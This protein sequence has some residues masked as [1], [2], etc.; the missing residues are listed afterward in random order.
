MKLTDPWEQDGLCVANWDLKNKKELSSHDR[1]G[2]KS[3]TLFSK[4]LQ[5]AL[6][7]FDSTKVTEFSKPCNSQLDLTNKTVTCANQSGLNRLASLTC[8]SGPEWE[9]EGSFF[10][11]GSSFSCS[12]RAYSGLLLKAMSPWFANCLGKKAFLTKSL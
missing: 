5:N 7:S 12:D 1:T 9:P 4:K 10:Y 3:R 11:K 8:I 6:L 2:I